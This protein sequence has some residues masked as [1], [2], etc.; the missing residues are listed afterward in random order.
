MIRTST[1]GIVIHTTASNSGNLPATIQNFFLRV[2][3]WKTGGY[4][5]IYP[6]VGERKQYYDWKTEATNGIEPN[7]GYSNSNT[8]HLSYIGGINNANQNEAVCNITPSQ[9]RQMIEDIRLILR[10]YPNAKILGHNQINLKYCPSF[11][12]P[13]WLRKHGIS[14]NNIDEIDPFMVKNTIKK[15]PHPFNF[16]TAI[17]NEVRTCQCCGQKI[18]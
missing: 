1:K 7:L 16:Y 6:Q 18:D 11:W 9:E 14:E 13:D 3:R 10:W 2:R 5:I 15:L 17:N 4:H 8:I 12:T